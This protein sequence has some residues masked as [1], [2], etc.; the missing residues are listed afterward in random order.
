MN[1]HPLMTD[2]G[3]AGPSLSFFPATFPCGCTSKKGAVGF[4]GDRERDLGPVALYRPNPPQKTPM[5]NSYKLI[6]GCEGS[7]R[8]MGGAI[9]ADSLWW[10]LERERAVSAAPNRMFSPYENLNLWL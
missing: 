1:S 8:W 3:D 7:L 9:V 6:A 10:D 2:S 4:L 5:L